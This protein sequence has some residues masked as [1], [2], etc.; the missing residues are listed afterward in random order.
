[1]NIVDYPNTRTISDTIIS[2]VL[3]IAFI[4]AGIGLLVGATASS[5]VIS[6]MLLNEWQ[7]NLSIKHKGVIFDGYEECN[8][9]VCGI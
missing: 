8:N 2:I 5:V 3:L 7:V 9:G 1:M 6:L 4:P